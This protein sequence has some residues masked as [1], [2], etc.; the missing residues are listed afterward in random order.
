ML[1]LNFEVPGNPGDYYEIKNKNDG[2]IIYK[3]VRSKIRNLAQV[4]NDYFNYI[5]SSGENLHIAILE[6]N[7]VISSFFENEPEEAQLIIYSTIT[8]EMNALA[9]TINEQTTKIN[10]EAQQE[11]QTFENMGKAI[12]AIILVFVIILI[13]SQIK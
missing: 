1:S 5:L 8:E 10:E 13:L 12:G 11:K 9:S 2:S 7:D 4:Q 3:S 6:S